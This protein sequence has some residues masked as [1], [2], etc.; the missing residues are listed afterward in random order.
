MKSS[1]ILIS[2]LVVFFFAASSQETKPYWQQQVNYQINVRLNDQLHQLD[3]FEKIEY[4]NHS[5]DT[6]YYIWFHLWPN[7]YSN[8]NTAFAKQLLKEPD[9][10]R[11]LKSMKD[12]GAVF[13]LNF[14]VNDH[15]LVTSNHPEY[16][17]VLKVFLD[18]P[19]YPG[20]KTIISTPFKVNLPTYISRMGHIGK[21]YMICQWYPKPAVYDRKGWHPMPYL[22]RGEFYSEFGNYNVSI[23]LPSDYVLAATGT[24]QNQDELAYYKKLGTKNRLSRKNKAYKYQLKE[25]IKTIRYTCENLHDFSWFADKDFIIEYDSLLLPSGKKIDVFAYHPSYGNKLWDSAHS[26]MKEAVL[27]YSNW[28]GEYPYPLVQAVEGPKNLSSGGMEYPT[29]TLITSPNADSESLDAVIAHEIGHNWFYGILGSNE[30]DHAW[31]DEG[32]NSYYQFRYEAERYRSNSTFGYSLPAELK[33]MD[34]DKFLHIIYMYFAAS[35][36]ETPIATASADF[37]NFEE[38]ARVEY[39]KAAAWMY[40]I[41]ESI[42]K[43][44]ID[45]AMKYYFDQWKFRHPYPEDFKQSLEEY[46]KTDLSILFDLLNKRGRLK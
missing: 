39:I 28:I 27:S 1:L 38:Y 33:R 34:V 15:K 46:L 42:G 31:M 41:E 21:S 12:T 4:I 10:K 32:I 30:R 7:A 45:N 23:T 16:N 19:L 20:A 13:D 8:R 5:P 35:G 18:K 14:S 29:I 43:E 22:D 44:K 17:D 3:A 6:L 11:L 25:P 26:Y 24:L 37:P 36:F 40:Q 9:G 2:S